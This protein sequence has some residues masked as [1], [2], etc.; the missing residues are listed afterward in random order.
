MSRGRSD[1]GVATAGKSW[2]AQ[3]RLAWARATNRQVADF[4]DDEPRMAAWAPGTIANTRNTVSQ[5]LRWAQT[6]G[7]MEVNSRLADI[8][9]P[10]SLLNWINCQRHRVKLGTIERKLVLI[11][12][13][14]QAL[15]AVTMN[16]GP[17]VLTNI[18]PPPGV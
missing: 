13:V 3:D 10:I 14:L 8:V 11:H 5:F 2:P 18:G 16:F 12:A 1:D 4:L 15:V 7:L 17:L 6:E 9:T